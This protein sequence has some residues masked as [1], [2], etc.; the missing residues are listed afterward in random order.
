MSATS[1][2][3]ENPTPLLQ[4][5]RNC[6]R[7]EHARRFS[8]L[9]D[10]EVY[11]RALRAAIL[12]ARHS[13]FI[14]S[15]DI[16]SRIRLVPAGANDGYP[17]QFGDF[18]Y[19]VAE[20]RPE[21]H[22]HVLNW[23]FAMLFAL[24]RKWPA[25]R[26]GWRGHR[27]VKFHMDAEHPVGAS[28]H[29]KVVVIDDGLAFA[30][31]LD[32]TRC[33]WDTPDHPGESPLRRD[34]DG[35][36]YGPFHDVQAIV[37]GD[38]ARA[39]GELARLRWE[40]ATSQEPKA[41]SAK[42]REDLWPEDI[43]PDVTDINVGIAR[44]EPAYN[45]RKGVYEVRQLHLD[46][47][48]AARQRLFFENQYF[49]SD[50]ICNAL[51]AR[52]IEDDAPEIM[53]VMPKIQSGW[54]EQSTM[55][56][57]RARVHRRLKQADER[58]R[59]R[60][61]CADLPGLNDDCCLNVHSKVFTVD[62]DILCVG[63]ANLSNRSM[64]LDTECKLVIEAHGSRQDE[65]RGAIARLRSRLMAEHLD[66]K[67]EQVAAEL[68]Q[69][70]SLHATVAALQ[71]SA[72]SLNVF[73]PETTPELDALIPDQ[74]VLDPEKPI[75]PDELIEQLVPRDIHKPVPRRMI[76]LGVLAVAL[77][78]LAIAWRWTP[79]GEM[80]NLAALIKLARSL[81]ALPFT[82]LAVILG[83]VVAGMLMVPVMLL[84]GV[85]GI[86]FG[87]LAGG[88]YAAGGTLLSA[89]ISYG[90]GR[91]LGKDGIHRILGARMDRI[92]RRLCKQGIVAMVV[93]RL[94]PVAP[95]TVVNVLA[96]ALQIRFR[97]YLIGTILGMT[98]GIVITV[99]FAH[100]LAEA[101]RNPSPEV[102]SVLAGVAILLIG[103]AVGLQRLFE[104]RSNIQAQ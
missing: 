37:D 62:D 26:L 53:I 87:P 48:A 56:V 45:G 89:T 41:A 10:A 86:V 33:R 67:P 104:R 8:M 44:T 34:S 16:D 25:A 66:V 78:L 18:L 81:E 22:I 14:L 28:H 82:P 9:V 35:K 91:W 4:P 75:D 59:Y 5:G 85:T 74:A 38:A 76:V 102:I 31:G 47:I 79:L 90:V 52:L 7:I 19:A 50:L 70:N 27:R 40:R 98:P 65:I 60:M 32:I 43:A 54:L 1:H 12:K 88:L 80:V 23:D 92:S 51:A 29:Q 30:G 83:Y 36:P 64:S 71:G 2:A 6:W 15:W 97:D 93:T 84:I 20:A 49:T 46:A 69:R 95:F 103:T 42:P 94:L 100:H 21:L 63:S 11:F 73:D 3:V 39:L 55:G 17:E 68:Q 99:T 57:L 58:G 72:R 96:G 101:V 77:A 61:Y 24:E 13:V